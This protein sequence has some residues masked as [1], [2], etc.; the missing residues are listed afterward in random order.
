MTNPN[1]DAID[2]DGEERDTEVRLL[3]NTVLLHAKRI[4]NSTDSDSKL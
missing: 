3:S 4:Q 1:C 2:G